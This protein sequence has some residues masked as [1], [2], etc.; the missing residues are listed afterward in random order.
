[1]LATAPT[2]RMSIG[3]YLTGTGS[4][5]STSKV[6][7]LGGAIAA[8]VD[9]HGD[10][11]LEVPRPFSGPLDLYPMATFPVYR[12]DLRI[13]RL[14]LCLAILLDVPAM[15]RQLFT[16]ILHCRLEGPLAQL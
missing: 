8:G 1:M 5:T 11:L 2:A 6:G 12:H 15:L 9:I 10:Q 3:T 13:P 16:E 4:R 7:S 14:R